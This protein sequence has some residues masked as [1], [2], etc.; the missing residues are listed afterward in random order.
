MI[1]DILDDDDDRYTDVNK[2]H[3][4][5]FLPL[6]DTFL[7]NHSNLFMEKI[8]ICKVSSEKTVKNCH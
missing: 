4:L 6:S 8:I 1:M 7:Y 2:A 5:T 3:F